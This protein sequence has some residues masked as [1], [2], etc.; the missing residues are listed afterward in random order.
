M[1]RILQIQIFQ[2]VAELGSF[3]R[4]AEQLGL[5]KTTVSEAVQRLEQQLG[6]R[7][8]HR[9]T[10][11][12]E[13]TQDGHSYY[14]RCLDVLA[15]FDELQQMFNPD[16]QQLQGVLRID[17]QTSFASELVIPRLPEFLAAHPDLHIQLSSTDRKV[18]LIA[19]GFDAVLRV[20][21]LSDS[22]LIARK[23]GEMPQINCASPAYLQ[24]FG[25]PAELNDLQHHQLVNYSQQLSGKKA[26]F[27]Y[28]IGGNT[29]Y[30]PMRSVVTVNNAEAYTAACLAGLGIIQVPEAVTRPLLRS[31]ELI[32]ILPD[33]NGP[34]MPVSVLYA[35]RRLVSRKLRTFIQ[36][37]EHIITP[38]FW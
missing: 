8:L 3:T 9:T 29:Q 5:P 22:S 15:G 4:C 20:G 34:A 33:Y 23:L 1:D 18:D 17:M 25:T 7:L 35:N 30:L 24:R 21:Q 26:E 16:D 11:K 38:G 27:E 19:E 28:V 6:N 37:L 10:R 32:R 31:G 2:R 14:Q 12:V 13:L 36:W